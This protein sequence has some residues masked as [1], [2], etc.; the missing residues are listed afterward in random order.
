MAQFFRSHLALIGSVKIRESDTDSI[1]N[2][3][4]YL[5]VYHTKSGRLLS[6]TERLANIQL[7]KGKKVM[8]VAVFLKKNKNFA[9]SLGA[10]LKSIYSAGQ[11]SANLLKLTL[12]GDL[13]YRASN[14]FQQLLIA[15]ISAIKNLTENI[16][17]SDS[18]TYI[19]NTS[20]DIK[21]ISQKIK[22]T[23]FP[24]FNVKVSEVK[25]NEI[26]LKVAIKE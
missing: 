7:E 19:A 26:I 10:Q 13:S 16:I 20:T 2:L 14:Q 4:L 15:K 5:T 1:L 17:R 3:K 21:N 6:E 8:P 25:K 11:I 23:L 24:G 9:K 12:K 18:I 22:D